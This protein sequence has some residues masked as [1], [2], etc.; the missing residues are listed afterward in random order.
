MSCGI[1]EHYD[2]IETEGLTYFDLSF[3][4][5]KLE[6]PRMETKIR[7]N[8]LCLPYDSIGNGALPP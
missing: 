2:A 8:Y 1:H 5:L 4:K 3:D 7:K 6:L